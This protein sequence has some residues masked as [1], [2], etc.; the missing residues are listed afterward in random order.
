MP[1]FESGFTPGTIGV[2]YR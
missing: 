1:S 2:G